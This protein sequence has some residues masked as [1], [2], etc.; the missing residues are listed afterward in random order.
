M[1]TSSTSSCES[2]PGT[3][4]IYTLIGSGGQLTGYSIRSIDSRNPTICQ[5]NRVKAT[6]IAVCGVG[7]VL[8]KS[9]VGVVGEVNLGSTS[10]FTYVIVVLAPSRVDEVIDIR[11]TEIIHAIKD[12]LDVVHLICDRTH[13]IVAKKI[14]RFAWQALH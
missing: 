7:Q 14:S 2:S 11:I 12:I 6:W 10:T 8:Q 9:F 1:V 13:E 5:K 3:I 4:C